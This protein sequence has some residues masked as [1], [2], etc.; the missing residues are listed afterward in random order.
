M[1]GLGSCFVNEIELVL[2]ILTAR[3]ASGTWGK[4]RFPSIGRSLDALAGCLSAKEPQVPELAA[5]QT[6]FI[7]KSYL[8][9]FPMCSFQGTVVTDALSA[10]R[11]LTDSS[12]N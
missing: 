10:F 7:Q 4:A 12:L 6:G 8:M 11:K 2:Q 1:P 5:Q 9:S 3:S